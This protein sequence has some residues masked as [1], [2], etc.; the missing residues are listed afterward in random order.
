[1]R[2]SETQISG[3]DRRLL[4]TY[5]RCNTNYID[6]PVDSSRHAQ[7]MEIMVEMII[8]IMKLSSLF[9]QNSSMIK[10][11]NGKHTYD[12]WAILVTKIVT[13]RRAL[14][15]S[16]LVKSGPGRVHL[17]DHAEG[18]VAGHKLL[19]QALELVGEVRP[20]LAL[21][22]GL[23]DQLQGRDPLSL[24]HGNVE[25]VLLRTHPNAVGGGLLGFGVSN[26]RHFEGGG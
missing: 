1:M 10:A 17:G 24:D 8:F 7:F 20:A 6:L 11:K 26:E 9:L 19:E 4:S 16:E 21:G 25:V 13:I 22:N 14:A 15:S 2:T 18:G 12:R 5:T 3:V 23:E